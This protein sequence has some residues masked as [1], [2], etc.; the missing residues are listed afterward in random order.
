MK[1][2]Y[3][4]L[5]ILF[6]FIGVHASNIQVSLISADIDPGDKASLQ[7]GF[8]YYMNYCSGCHS[9]KYLR[10]DRVARDLGITNYEGQVLNKVVEDNL[11]F[12]TDKILDNITS[13]LSKQDAEKW[14]GVAAPDLTLVTRWRS[15]DW[16]YTYLKSFYVD[17][18]RPW[19]VNNYLFKDV[20]MPNIL[21]GV[22]RN[23]KLSES[24]DRITL[25][26]VNFLNYAAEP[27]KSTRKSIGIFVLLFLALLA[28]FAY[29][30]KKEYW[31]DLKN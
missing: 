18:N 15:V 25:D 5:F 2:L 23:P 14:F 21:D 31:K 4:K 6:S 16:V 9:L 3:F 13:S 8:K 26:I 22:I 10:Y 17:K 30:L 11:M 24:L 19:G 29:L 27:A 20:A 28:V 1:K 7:R 12:N